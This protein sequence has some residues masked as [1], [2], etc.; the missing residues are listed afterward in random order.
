MSKYSRIRSCSKLQLALRLGAQTH[1]GCSFQLHA[2]YQSSTGY[3][4]YVCS[5]RVPIPHAFSNPPCS[6]RSLSS[7]F[8]TIPNNMLCKNNPNATYPIIHFPPFAKWIALAAASSNESTAM[9]ATQP[10]HSSQIRDKTHQKH[11]TSTHCS[12]STPA[13]TSRSCPS[14]APQPAP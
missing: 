9:S 11:P 5:Q 13:L 12:G 3:F 7:I 2:I 8:P 6:K 1:T 10:P 4:Y 14:T